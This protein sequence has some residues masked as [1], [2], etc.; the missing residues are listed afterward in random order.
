MISVC[1]YPGEREEASFRIAQNF[2]FE[3]KKFL[4]KKWDI[5]SN[6]F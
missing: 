2:L 1:R 4:E 3:E 6:P 5:F